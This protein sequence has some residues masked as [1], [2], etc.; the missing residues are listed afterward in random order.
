MHA[1]KN[2]KQENDI[3]WFEDEKDHSCGTVEDG[4][5]WGRRTTWQPHSRL[6]EPS[7]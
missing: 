2:I 1:L 7:R 6:F 4:L 3:I 5:E